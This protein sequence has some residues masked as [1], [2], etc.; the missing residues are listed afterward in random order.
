MQRQRQEKARPSH[1]NWTPCSFIAQFQ[2]EQEQAFIQLKVKLL[3]IYETLCWQWKGGRT[4]FFS[5][6][7]DAVEIKLVGILR[8]AGTDAGK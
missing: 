7:F 5:S 4:K 8:A 1:M 6:E 3:L 2:G